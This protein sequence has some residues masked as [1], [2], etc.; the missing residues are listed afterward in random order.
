MSHT[1]LQIHITHAGYHTIMCHIIPDKVCVG[2][3]LVPESYD[4]QVLEFLIYFKIK[5]FLVCAQ[6]MG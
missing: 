4:C 3:F 2:G 6:H 5:P 1:D